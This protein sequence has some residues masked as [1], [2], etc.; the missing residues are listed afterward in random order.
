MNTLYGFR[1]S[2]NICREEIRND[3][4]HIAE[5]SIIEGGNGGRGMD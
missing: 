2:T 3:A 4:G 5:D 1:A